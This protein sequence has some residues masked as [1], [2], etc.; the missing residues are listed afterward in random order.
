MDD[1]PV[2]K[3]EQPTEES[4]E[5]HETECVVEEET[6]EQ[7]SS[8][9]G[10]EVKESGKEEPL[11]EPV[12]GVEHQE[13]QEENH[14]NG[15]STKEENNHF[16]GELTKE[17]EENN[18]NKE[19]EAGDSIDFQK[20]EFTNNHDDDSHHTISELRSKWDSFGKEQ[21][22]PPIEHIHCHPGMADTAKNRFV[23]TAYTIFMIYSSRFSSLFQ[24]T[25]FIF[26]SLLIY[27][28]VFVC[29]SF[30]SSVSIY[31]FLQLS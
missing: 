28:T 26:V 27:L 17:E 13:D 4:V 16:E 20:K 15:T 31:L 5:V 8:P 18:K 24:S 6:G 2:I 7:V 25:V 30:Q 9:N 19:Q 1:K 3:E 10:E 14:I 23:S 12:N 11:E 22:S 21:S 29:L